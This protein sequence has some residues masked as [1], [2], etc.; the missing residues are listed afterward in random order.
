QASLRS[1][2]EFNRTSLAR[3]RDGQL[4]FLARSA[5][6][7]GYQQERNPELVFSA[8]KERQRADENHAQ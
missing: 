4:V 1:F 3:D 7:V 2:A 8:T 5:W 6:D